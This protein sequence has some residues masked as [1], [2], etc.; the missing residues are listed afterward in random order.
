MISNS[1]FWFDIDKASFT[2]D[3][4]CKSLDVYGNDSATMETAFEGML[5]EQMVMKEAVYLVD[6]ENASLDEKLVWKVDKI[7]SDVQ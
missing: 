4:I 1:S 7:I 6:S 3:P 5:Y 2:F